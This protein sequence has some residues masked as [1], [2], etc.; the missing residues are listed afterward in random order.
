MQPCIQ[1]W[2]FSFLQVETCIGIS[3]RIEIEIELKEKRIRARK[4]EELEAKR[5]KRK[6]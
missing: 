3:E 1:I 6:G 4:E 2:H 5:W